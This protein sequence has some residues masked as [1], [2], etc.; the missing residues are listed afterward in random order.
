M[1][2]A[3][4]EADVWGDAGAAAG[5][6]EAGCVGEEEKANLNEPYPKREASHKPSVKPHLSRSLQ[7]LRLLQ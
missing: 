4:V 1:A 7:A 3:T 6:L 5:E 2:P